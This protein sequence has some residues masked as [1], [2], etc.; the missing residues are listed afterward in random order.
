MDD[1]TEYLEGELNISDFQY[2][3]DNGLPMN[4]S[5]QYYFETDNKFL[6]FDRTCNGF[7]INNWLEGTK[8]TFYGSRNEIKENLFLLANRT[9]TGYTISDIEQLKK[10]KTQEYN[11]YS[12][13]Y[14][15]AL[16]FQITDKGEIGYKYLV[17]DC[18]KEEEH[19]VNILSGFS[20]ENVIKDKEWEVVNIKIIPKNDVM[21][22]YFYVNGKLVYITNELPIINFRKLNEIYEKQEGVP[23]NI[24]LGG[25]SQ[26]LAE[27]IMP[28]YM[29]LP[30]KVYPIEKHFA[31]TF[32]GWIK[33]FKFYT[34]GMEYMNIYNNFMYEKKQIKLK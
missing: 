30:T 26:G 10:N 27:T 15:N 2:E 24:S 28:N 21:I 12:D 9:K 32:I 6:L 13:L 31:G 1:G 17:L 22:I 5:K 34:C 7:N 16:A 33:S 4:I 20:Y 11:P 14:H 18:D 19:Y 8:V 29:L 23:Y 3:T 25:G